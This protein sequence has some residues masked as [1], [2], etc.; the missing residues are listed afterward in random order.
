MSTMQVIIYQTDNGGVAVVYPAPSF[1]GSLGDLAVATVPAGAAWRMVDAASLPDQESR[2]RWRWTA[3]GP[4][5]V[6]AP[7][8]VV[9]PQITKIQLVRAMRAL[10][11]WD[12]HRAVIEAHPDWPY[13]TDV[14][15]DDPLTLAASAV[16]DATP[17][18][19]DAIWIL[20]ATL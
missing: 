9:P 18:Q 10:D 16:M 19:M 17:E 20:G 15:R 8:I 2:E 1:A 6:A 3:S 13:I 5:D 4:L 14:P 7:E 11:L 12:A